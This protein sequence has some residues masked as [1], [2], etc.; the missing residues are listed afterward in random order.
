MIDKMSS[1][2]CRLFFAV[3]LFLLIL[4]LWDGFLRL[5]GWTISWLYGPGRVLEFAAMLITFVIAILLRQIREQ[6]KSK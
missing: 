2:I 1:T 5:F 6:L 4:A 3:G